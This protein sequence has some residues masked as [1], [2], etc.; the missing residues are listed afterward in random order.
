VTVSP[1]PAAVGQDITITARAKDANNATVTDYAA[2]TTVKDSAGAIDASGKFVDGVSTTTAKVTSAVHGEV[3]YVEDNNGVSGQSAAFNVVGPADHLS[4]SVPASVDANGPFDVTARALDVAGNTVTGY[5]GSASW[6]DSNGVLSPSSPTNFVAGVSKTSATV[7]SP[8]TG[9]LITL[10]SGGLSVQ[11]KFTAFGLVAQLDVHVPSS[12][13]VGTPFPM[14]VSARDEAGNLVTNYPG[15]NDSYVGSDAYPFLAPYNNG[16]SRN[17][18][19]WSRPEHQLQITVLGLSGGISNPINVLGPPWRPAQTFQRTDHSASCASI[20]GTL[21]LKMEDVAGNFLS[22]Y[23]ADP[24]AGMDS[25][26]VHDTPV[27]PGRPA[28]YVRGVSKTR[29][30]IANSDG[31]TQDSLLLGADPVQIC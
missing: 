5:S 1:R 16:V 30:S 25:V 8:T 20:K 22:D 17:T 31:R 15:T 14:T 29:L 27:Q 4:L 7:S 23:N 21:T 24:W 18:V 19:T 11:K 3:V 26:F 28:P 2:Y 6:S 13:K 9:D 12:A 10:T